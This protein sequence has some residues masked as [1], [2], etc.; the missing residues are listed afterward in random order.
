MLVLDR[1]RFQTSTSKFSL[2]KQSRVIVNHQPFSQ[3]LLKS[4]QQPLH[5]P[6]R[7]QSFFTSQWLKPPDQL[8]RILEITAKSLTD[9]IGC[10]PSSSFRR[11]LLLI[12]VSC[13]G[14]LAE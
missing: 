4:P 5:R 2:I 11:S 6:E 9:G 12:R 10:I 14:V 3:S 1:F 7:Q 8:D 13:A